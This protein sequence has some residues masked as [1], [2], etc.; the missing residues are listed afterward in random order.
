MFVVD[1]NLFYILTVNRYTNK[2]TVLCI[3]ENTTLTKLN[4]G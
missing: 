2:Y 3:E 4:V 1:F